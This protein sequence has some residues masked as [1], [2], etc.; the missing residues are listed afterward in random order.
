MPLREMP[1]S[2]CIRSAIRS[3]TPCPLPTR[4]PPAAAAA[5][6][7]GGGGD[8]EEGGGDGGAI[9]HSPAGDGTVTF[10]DAE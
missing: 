2:T 5:A 4:K 8:E 10:C 6:A 3:P 9:L 1:K 7:G